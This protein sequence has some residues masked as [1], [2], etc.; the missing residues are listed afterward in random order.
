MAL[1]SNA[2]TKAGNG[3]GS[4]TQIISAA[5][6]DQAALDA[7]EKALGAAGHSIA[8]VAGAHGGTMHFAI[9]GGGT[10]ANP[11][12]AEATTAIATFED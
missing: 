4:V 7:F 3:L 9:Q 12:G 6:A 8:G 10:V 11:T 1:T 5:P 2:A